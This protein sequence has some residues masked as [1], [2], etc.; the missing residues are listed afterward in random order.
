M[1]LTAMSAR[2]G[3]QISPPLRA[4]WP[5]RTVTC[6]RMGRP[7]LPR[8]RR[9][10]GTPRVVGIVE[11]IERVRLAGGAWTADAGGGVAGLVNGH[12]VAGQA[13]GTGEIVVEHCVAAEGVAAGGRRRGDRR[14]RAPRAGWR[15]A[16]FAYHRWARRLRRLR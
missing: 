15:A 11:R 7:A 14:R 3:G 4:E 12:G 6:W 13:A 9:L 8:L 5:H 1:A 16:R 2:K 10:D